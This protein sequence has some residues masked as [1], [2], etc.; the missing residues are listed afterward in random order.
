VLPFGVPQPVTGSQPVAAWKAPLSPV[1]TS[2]SAPADWSVEYRSG[3]RKP[4]REPSA[5]LR[6]ATRPAQSGATA[7]VPPKTALV[8]STR[9]W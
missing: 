2:D 1:V 7:L 8:P 6:T 4:T 9:I 5:L 3:F